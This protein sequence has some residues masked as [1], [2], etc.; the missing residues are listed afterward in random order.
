MSGFFKGYVLQCIGVVFLPC[1]CSSVRTL[2][3]D[4]TAFGQ[5]AFPAFA[6]RRSACTAKAREQQAAAAV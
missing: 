1:F 6:R 2:I 3:Q 5:A 4:A